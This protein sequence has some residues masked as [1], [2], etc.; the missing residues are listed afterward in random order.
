M[1]PP[2][3]NS[4]RPCPN[5]KGLVALWR[6]Y[7]MATSFISSHSSVTPCFFCVLSPGVSVG[8]WHIPSSAACHMQLKSELVHWLKNYVLISRAYVV[9]LDEV[10]G[11]WL[12]LQ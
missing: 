9:V 3:Q 2:L 8:L 4:T 12:L 10:Y 5:Q 7:M 11:Q 1:S 6:Y